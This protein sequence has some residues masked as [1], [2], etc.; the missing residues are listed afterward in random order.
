LAR[1]SGSAISPI[2]TLSQKIHCQLM[3]SVTVPPTS[4]P[5]VVYCYD[6]L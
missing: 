1:A 5:I 4:G 2:G 3:P 6:Y